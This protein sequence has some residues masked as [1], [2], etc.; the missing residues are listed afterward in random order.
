MMKQLF[1]SM[2]SARMGLVRSLLDSAEI[3]YEVRNK[4]VSQAVV[5][6]AFQEELWV[7]EDD[8][9]DAAKLLAESRSE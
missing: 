7:A 5:G 1:S 4:A 3:A 6:F 2:D 8:Y 9:A